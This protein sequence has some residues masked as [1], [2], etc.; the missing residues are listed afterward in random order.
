MTEKDLLDKGFRS[1]SGDILTI[2]YHK[3]IC[4]H[5]GECVKGDPDV[6]D[7]DRRPWIIP[8][9]DH[10]ENIVSTIKKCPT[11]ALKYRFNNSSEIL[12]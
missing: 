8:F 9:S 2:Y 4:A 1:Y 10:T 7:V 11:G 5:V 3:D 12:P 6:F